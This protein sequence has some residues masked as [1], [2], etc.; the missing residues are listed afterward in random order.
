M[1]GVDL[2]QAYKRDVEAAVS[3]NHQ[4]EVARVLDGLGVDHTLNELVADGLFCADIMIGSHHIV[5]QVDGAHH[6]TSNTGQCIGKLH[7]MM[8]A[9]MTRT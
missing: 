3:S 7:A 2:L 6:W 4:C 8:L 5:I 9:D 1:L